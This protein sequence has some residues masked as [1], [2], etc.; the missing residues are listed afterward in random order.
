MEVALQ[1]LDSIRDGLLDI[2]EA[3][4]EQQEA[5]LDVLRN[6]VVFATADLPHCKPRKYD[7]KQ[8]ACNKGTPKIR[9][10][11]IQEKN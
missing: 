1:K 5:L 7:G 4:E 6:S 10:R 2:F 11:Y 8:L 3:F 9:L